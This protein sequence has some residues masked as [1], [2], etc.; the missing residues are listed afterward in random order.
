MAF[1]AK[2]PAS[3]QDILDLPDHL[4]GQI[5]AGE[6]HVQPRPA[7]RHAIAVGGLFSELDPP[8]KRGRGP[9][10][11]IIP[12]EPELHLQR[13]V[14][15]PDLAGWRPERMPEVPVDKAYFDLAPD[16]VAEGL[17]RS[18]ETFDRGTK[19]KIY[20][21]ERVPHVWFVNAEVQSLEVLRL[22]GE[23]Y[24]V[25]DVFSGDAKLRGEPF[26]AIELDLAVLWQR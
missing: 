18:T 9:G 17:S 21:R 19:L 8:F 23:T 14:L 6:L 24:R 20:A 4:T 13:D 16:W 3:Y 15:V 1:A 12:F 10:G 11:W 26:D 2:R 5:V 7:P 25:I 22:D